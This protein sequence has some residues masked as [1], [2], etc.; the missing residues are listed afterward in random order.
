MKH[1]WFSFLILT[2]LILVN[3]SPKNNF[4]G[5]TSDLHAKGIINGGMISSLDPISKHIVAITDQSLENCTGTLIAEN[6][7]L[8][9]AHC[10]T[11]DEKMYV[12]FGLEI[13][14]NNVGKID[15]HEVT[16]YRLLPGRETVGRFFPLTDRLDLMIL[17]FEGK[18]PSGYVPAEILQDSSVLV[19]GAFVT[20]AGYGV[21]NSFSQKGDGF[22]RKAQVPIE[23]ANFSETEISTDESLR[24]SCSIDSGGP[25]FIDVNG[26]TY[27][28]GVTSRGD[29]F[30]RVQGIYTKISS[31]LPWVKAVIKE[32]SN[33]SK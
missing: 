33:P 2:S 19:E 6:L 29:A 22:L 16:A 32:L 11:P 23:N 8:T 14:E 17:R 12:A 3:C 9:A 1:F 28:W 5:E 15:L 24:A 31:Y 13:S 25:A 27:I 21:T 30:C 26:K 7:V 10:E 18:A 20:L 4:K